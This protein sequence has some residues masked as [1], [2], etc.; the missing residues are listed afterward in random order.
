NL[1]TNRSNWLLNY[2]RNTITNKIIF[3]K[4]IFL[5]YTQY[6]IFTEKFGR[7]VKITDVPSFS[8]IIL[9]FIYIHILY[10]ILVK[11]SVKYTRTT[12]THTFE[13]QKKFY[14]NCFEQDTATSAGA[15]LKLALRLGFR[16][17]VPRTFIISSS[18]ALELWFNELTVFSLMPE[19]VPGNAIGGGGGGGAGG[20]WWWWWWRSALRRCDYSFGFSKLFLDLLAVPYVLASLGLVFFAIV[21]PQTKVS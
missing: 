16:R 12:D 15:V 20:W 18:M 7:N 19:V 5:N 9:Y 21:P 10:I 17:S 6:L 4:R 2:Y 14:N 8:T 13:E 3:L 1:I 11:I